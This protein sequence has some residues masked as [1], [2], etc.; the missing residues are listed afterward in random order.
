MFY[1]GFGTLPYP[2]GSD[3]A[4]VVESFSDQT[5]LRI[6]ELENIP[7]NPSGTNTALEIRAVKYEL[8][9]RQRGN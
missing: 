6:L 2:N 5:L 9:R 4:L 3:V 8:D 1:D 7:R